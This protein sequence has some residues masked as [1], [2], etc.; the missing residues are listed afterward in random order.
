MNKNLKN[1]ATIII[2]VW[3][4]CTQLFLQSCN[5]PVKNSLKKQANI[6]EAIA[7]RDFDKA[8][9]IAR[10]IVGTSNR[11]PALYRINKAQ[12]SLAM[13][14]SLEDAEALAKELDA[15]Y[16]YWE[17]VSQQINKLYSKD[18]RALYRVLIAYKFTAP[19]HAEYTCSDGLEEWAVGAATRMQ[20]GERRPLNAN[21]YY[22]TNVGYNT[23]V[24]KYNEIVS[25][26]LNLAIFEGNADD[27][28]KI[29]PLL[30]PEA[31]MIKKTFV[32]ESDVSGKEYKRTFKLENKAKA[33]ALR[34]IKEAGINL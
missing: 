32:E 13:E 1:T 15:S 6:E 17:L 11:D 31:V 24:A 9:E 23:E 21:A 2:A 8:R 3:V 30:K 19:Y 7:N 29:L 16:E 18:F 25:Q 28:R 34:K 5:N 12:I 33:D 26:A 22:N 20:N 14:N 27:V 4:S 10:T